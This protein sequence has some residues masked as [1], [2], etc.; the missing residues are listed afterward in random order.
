MAD[1]EPRRFRL[2]AFFA[3]LATGALAYDL[4][5]GA[6]YITLLGGMVGIG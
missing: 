4:L 1:I 6:E 3:L 5:T 2:Y